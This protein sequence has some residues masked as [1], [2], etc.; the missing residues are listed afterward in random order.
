MLVQPIKPGDWHSVGLAIRQI[1]QQLGP[2]AAV[3][4]GAMILSELAAGKPVTVDGAGKLI[5]SDL[6]DGLAIISG[7]SLASA[8]YDEVL[9]A[10]LI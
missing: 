3:T 9:G 10:Y 5:S 4:F 6:A 1:T 7:G 8:P 2:R